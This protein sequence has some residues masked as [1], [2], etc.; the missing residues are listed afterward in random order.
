MQQ[1]SFNVYNAS[2]GS[3]KTFSLVKNY[4]KLLLSAPKNDAYKYIL[5]ITFTNKAV[6]E[7]KNRVLKTLK[8][9]SNKTTLQAPSDMFTLISEE[10]NVPPKQLHEKS[11]QL[12]HSILHNY[13]AF[14]ILTIDGFNHKI[15]RTFA[16]DLKLSLNFEIELDSKSLLNKA[17]DSLIAKAGNNKLL[18]KTL[19]NYALSKVDD[20]KSWDISGD[21]NTI[22]QL[23]IN[24][25]DTF[26]IADLQNKT[27]E[28]F[29]HLKKILTEKSDFL[30]TEI[31]KNA[32]TVLELITNNGLDFSDFSRKTLPTH[33]L[34]A[35]QLNLNKLYD[36]KLEEN[37]ANHQ[38]IYTKT[39]A[40][41]KKAI[42]DGILPEIET[43]FH[44]IKQLVYNYKFISAVSKNST[45]LSVLNLINTELTQIKEEQNALFISDFNTLISTEIKNQPTPFIYERLGEK[46]KHY[47]VDEFQD[48]STMQWSNLIPLIDTNLSAQTGTAMLVGDVKQAIYRWRGGKAEQFLGLTLNDNP[49]Q[50]EKHVQQLEH[51]YRSYN[52]IITFNNAFFNYIATTNFS[53]SVYANLYA[54]A[55]QKPASK[56]TGYV[57]L[58]FLDF[59]KEDDKNDL[60]CEAVYNKITALKGKFTPK[61]I[62]ILVR[63]KKEAALIA[64]YLSSK[65]IAVSSFESMLL[66]NSP[67][68]NVTNSILK[69]L[70]KPTNTEEKVKILQYISNKYAIT[71]KHTFFKTHIH[72]ELAAFFEAFKA[73]DIHISAKKIIQ[74]P[75]Y[76]LVETIVR[77]FNLIT[78]KNAYIQYYLDVVFDFSQKNT[79]TI[80]EFVAYFKKNEDKL[81][82][83]TPEDL[84]A[85]KIMTIHKSKGLEFPVV[86]FPYAELDIYKE[87]DPKVWFP[88]EKND[89]ANFS[90]ALINYNNDIANFGSIGKTIHTQHQSE[91]ELDNINLLY[92]A[93]TRPV[94]QLYVIGK[95]DISNKGI[96]N[97]KTYSGIL[98]SY[99]QNKHLWSDTQ[100]TYCF[101]KNEKKSSTEKTGIT[102]THLNSFISVP[103]E[104]HNIKIVTNSGYLWDTAQEKAIERGNLI[105]KMMATITTKN[106]VDTALDDFFI[107]NNITANQKAALKQTVLAIVNHPKLS[108]FFNNTHLIYNEKDIITTNG[109]LLRPDRLN[110]NTNNE[111]VIIDYKTGTSQPKYEQQLHEYQ[112]VLEKMGYKIIR[113]ILVFINED[114]KLE[115]Y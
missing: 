42:I 96:V 74:R 79:A 60:Y 19:T 81:N 85:V 24:P 55:H 7:M 101:G 48:T 14:N 98:I 89:Y 114:I 45:Q 54:K 23:L 28:D 30:K 18:T 80:S 15:I 9:F 88:L 3:G 73:F 59:E 94:E 16:H 75:L 21:L 83:I 109:T 84:D 86:I 22:A 11:K 100:L 2:A 93:L 36:N 5:A 51:N 97:T 61:D 34:K 29:E 90:Y 71:D 26:Y 106:D 105:H 57:E 39:L 113:K 99:L 25:N 35:K 68:V 70:I 12:L 91:L 110:I 50:T 6:G 46:F 27:L 41:T 107:K 111:I 56:K 32:N 44:S 58:E 102:T 78:T 37:I 62:C 52:E 82:I 103:K 87:R 77:N 33:F 1:H 76:E 104:K 66:T 53:N 64:T 43:Y 95:K 67:E 4:L 112:T 40:D 65:N 10:L 49:F 108:P 47:F 92:V 17:V 13:G 31:S 38:S 63:K 8:E 72:L 69:V 115:E 20:D